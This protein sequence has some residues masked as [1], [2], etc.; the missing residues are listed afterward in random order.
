MKKVKLKIVSERGHDTLLL[1]PQEA[2]SR[3]QTET[4]QKGKWCYI[5]GVFAKLENMS[6]DSLIMA[7][8]IVLVNSLQGG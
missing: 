1:E 4:Q 2:L 5:N 6:M 7:D 3:I 8:S